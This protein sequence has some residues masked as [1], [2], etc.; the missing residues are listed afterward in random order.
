VPVRAPDVRPRARVRAVAGLAALLLAGV[1]D[2]GADAP[3]DVPSRG[4]V[5]REQPVPLLGLHWPRAHHVL[6]TPGNLGV[7][8]AEVEHEID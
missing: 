4:G 1:A 8:R 5:R 6:G 2:R 7:A 3:A